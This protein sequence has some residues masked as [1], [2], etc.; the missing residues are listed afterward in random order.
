[1]TGFAAFTV[2][3]QAYF[4][5]DDEARPGE[6]LYRRFPRRRAHHGQTCLEG[7]AQLVVLGGLGVDPEAGEEVDNCAE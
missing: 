6:A 7:D 4:K 2:S 5:R 3:E 1:M